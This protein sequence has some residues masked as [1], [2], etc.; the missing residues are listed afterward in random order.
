MFRRS[1]RTS[2]PV[3]VLR[4]EEQLIR[5][6]PGERKPKET[7]SQESYSKTTIWT[8]NLANTK[9]P[10]DHNFPSYVRSYAGRW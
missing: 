4:K 6:V 10:A 7:R 9:Y 2:V 5:H 8:R 3:Y 1:V